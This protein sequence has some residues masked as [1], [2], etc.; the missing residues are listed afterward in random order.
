MVFFYAAVSLAGAFSG[1]LAYAIQ[2]MDGVAG[3]EGW[4]WSVQ[5]PTK[6]MQITTLLKLTHRIFI[7][8]G[9]FTVFLSFFIWSL[10]PDSPGTAPF[11]T[12]E[13]RE[14]IVLRL[15]QDTGSGRGKVTN[16]D[17]VNKRQ[18]IAGLTDWKVWAAVV[19]ATLK[20]WIR[21]CGM[22]NVPKFMYWATSISSYGFTY[23]VP[24]VILELG[25]TAANAV[26]CYDISILVDI[27]SHF[28]YSN[29]LLFRFTLLL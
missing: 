18:V 7:L 12:T 16:N 23:T 8:E 1:L 10:L 20:T 14:F 28:L 19:S 17:K 15:E 11:L 4:R 27:N 3:L 25:Y 9:I 22:L 21:I 13:E 6:G 24:T 5:I 26:R 2:M 29:S